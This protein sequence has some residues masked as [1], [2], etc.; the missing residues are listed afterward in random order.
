[1]HV[2][3][4]AISIAILTVHQSNIS[5]NGWTGC[6]YVV[7]D[8]VTGAGAYKISGGLNG[9]DTP[10]PAALT[11]LMLG[12]LGGIA[13]VVI[14]FPPFAIAAGVAGFLAS[15]LLSQT[16]SE[17]DKMNFASAKFLGIV[18]GITLALIIGEYAIFSLS[19]LFVIGFVFLMLDI[20]YLAA[21]NAA[22]AFNT[23]SPMRLR[24]APKLA[25]VDRRKYFVPITTLI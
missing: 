3:D 18:A 5:L 7:L 24:S 6:G 20:L 4:T 17:Q 2:R 13:A 10:L 14:S 8:P 16:Y 1:M 15:L 9:D 25:R 11:G 12:L 23:I 21:V 19:I 22:T